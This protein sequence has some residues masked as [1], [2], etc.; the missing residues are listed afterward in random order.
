MIQKRFGALLMA[1][2]LGVGLLSGCGKPA[3]SPE[4]QVS[5]TPSPEVTPQATPQATPAPTP[6]Q[7]LGEPKTYYV[8]TTGSDE[9]DGSKQNPWRTLQH[10]VLLIQPGDTILVYPGT[11]EGFT[12]TPAL[13]GTAD[14]VKTIKNAL[15]KKPVINCAGPFNQ[16]GS[17]IEAIGGQ[18]SPVAYWVIDGL[19][20]E[21]SKKWG[22]DFVHTDH[23][24]VTNCEARRSGITGIF[25]AFSDNYLASYNLSEENGEHG[26]YFNNSADHFVFRGN[27][28]FNNQ[29]CGFHLN[30]DI[31]MGGDGIHSDGLYEY[32]ISS[33]N[34]TA[35]GAAYNLSGLHGG[36]VRNNLSYLD[37]AG[38]ITLYKG[39]SADT[40]RDVT[41]YNNTIILGPDSPRFPIRSD[42]GEGKA[43]NLTFYNNLIGVSKTEPFRQQLVAIAGSAMDDTVIF[44][45]NIAILADTQYNERNF[46]LD[47]EDEK[48]FT[49]PDQAFVRYTAQEVF[50]DAANNDY[51]LKEGSPAIDA[52]MPIDGLTDDLLGASRPQGGGIDIGC[53]EKAAG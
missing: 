7:A 26:Y 12:L 37:K 36:I 53:Y 22:I 43:L 27:R 1:L 52:G 16:R 33:G 10:A 42:G 51:T 45:H 48:P 13:N 14:G 2:L 35:G 23:M 17:N 21:D 6:T 20:S 31:S 46:I 3:S 44:D 50:T 11:Y 15:K 47:G 28:S 19:V 24:V 8:A 39:D 41:V 32:N 9:A 49:L 4:P 30:A 18:S 25:A 38:G 40:S 29:G 34:G 5:P